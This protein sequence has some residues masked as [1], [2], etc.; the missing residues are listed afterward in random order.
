MKRGAG[1]AKSI[2]KKAVPVTIYRAEEVEDEWYASKDDQPAGTPTPAK[3]H[4]IYG[5]EELLEH[6]D[7]GKRKVQ[8]ITA[9]STPK[10]IDAEFSVD[11]W[12]E[13]DGK[14]YTIKKAVKR[15]AADPQY[16]KAKAVS[17][18]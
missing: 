6:T 2:E 5:T 12:I 8:W 3:A 16:Y 4:I 15:P 18:T 13:F 14:R 9:Y 17:E 10:L 7:G 1:Q 11:E